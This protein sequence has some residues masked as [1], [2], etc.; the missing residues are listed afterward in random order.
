MPLTVIERQSLWRYH[1]TIK[2]GEYCV[3]RVAYREGDTFES[4]L[5][6]FRAKVAKAR[7]MS[8]V[9]KKRRFVPKS[10]RRR[11]ARRKAIRRERKRQWR[12]EAASGGSRARPRRLSRARR[13]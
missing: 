8:D 2:G 4:M 5:K 6:R 11:M 7:I 1:S 12:Q 9:K 3:T 13:R 10:E